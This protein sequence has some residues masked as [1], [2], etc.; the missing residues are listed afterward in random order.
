MRV[1]R[2]SAEEHLDEADSPFDQPAGDEAARPVLL[3]HVLVDAVELVDVQRLLS[4]IECFLRGSLHGCGQFIAGDPRF[5]I[6][7]ARMQ[8]EVLA[9]ES[10][11]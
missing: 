1:P 9:V 4:D 11:E 10:R 6:G 5:E 2:L 8:F 7:F 3:R